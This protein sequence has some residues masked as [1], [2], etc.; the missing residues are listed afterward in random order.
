MFVGEKQDP[1][2]A[3]QYGERCAPGDGAFALDRPLEPCWVVRD[4][5]VHRLV[6]CAGVVDTGPCARMRPACLVSALT[7]PEF[8]GSQVAG[9]WPRLG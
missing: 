1:T 2:R 6:E 9:T 5:H 8:G 4:S 7:M 3:S